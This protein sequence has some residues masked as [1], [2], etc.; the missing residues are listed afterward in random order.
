MQDMGEQLSLCFQRYL[1]SLSIIIDT[2]VGGVELHEH[3]L[4]MPRQRHTAP[5]IYTIL[6]TMSR[7]SRLRTTVLVF[8]SQPHTL[9]H[10]KRSLNNLSTEA[11]GFNKLY[12]NPTSAVDHR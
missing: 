9:A 8:L 2:H 7:C 3:L 1:A 6:C 12:D 10:V 4:R 11:N 5:L